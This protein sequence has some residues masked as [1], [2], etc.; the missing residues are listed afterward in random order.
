MV[1]PLTAPGLSPPFGVICCPKQQVFILLPVILILWLLRE[2]LCFHF[3]Y[4]VM[5]KLSLAFQQDGARASVI[6]SLLITLGYHIPKCHQHSLQVTPLSAG[7][8][9][10]RMIKSVQEGNKQEH[11]VPLKIYWW[12]LI[13]CWEKRAHS[14]TCEKQYVIIPSCP[15]SLETKH[16]AGNPIH[17]EFLMEIMNWPEHWKWMSVTQALLCFSNSYRLS[18]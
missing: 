13:H 2:S 9:W 6:L 7:R 16:R 3:P 15:F 11:T 18:G 14:L 4:W 8:T 12:P 5:S 17:Q 10:Y 1:Q